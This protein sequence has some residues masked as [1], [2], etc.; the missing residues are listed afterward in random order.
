AGGYTG[1]RPTVPPAAAPATPVPP[2]RPA[3]SNGAGTSVGSPTVAYP[4]IDALPRRGSTADTT[5]GRSA[6]VLPVGPVAGP[7]AVAPP[8]PPATP[9]PSV[10]PA[11]PA[12]PP[13]PAAPVS[14]RPEFPAEAPIFREMEAVWFRSHG[15]DATAIF[16]RPQ[17]DTPPAP[18]DA[19]LRGANG[20]QPATASA[21]A[22][23]PARPPLPT[24]TPG[25]S[26]GTGAQ[27]VGSMDGFGGANTGGRGGAS[28]GNRGGVSTGGRGASTPKPP[29]SYTP[30]AVPTAPVAA[31]A[32]TASTPPPATDPDAWRTAADEGWSL[33]SRA[34]EPAAAG[35]TRSGLPKRVPQAQLV[36]GGIEPK[37]GRDRSRRTPD[38]V[39]GLL[40]AYHR[41]VQRGRTAGTDLNSTSTKESR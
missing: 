30:P 9:A 21:P 18:A 38:E 29:P 24:R 8:A 32:A 7:G 22:S 11:P 25:S 3:Y 35:T 34:A 15:D 41:G 40:S 39:R 31:P 6:P 20:G 26:E 1:A 33:A 28:T 2:A 4:T 36:P 5:D 14:T 19:G 23:A 16:T 17:F 10:Q 13:T 12:T 37:G 27:S